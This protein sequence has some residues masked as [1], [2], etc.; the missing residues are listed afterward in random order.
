MAKIAGFFN[1]SNNV[2]FAIVAIAAV[3]PLWVSEFPPLVDLPQHA[4]QV[5]ALHEL[6]SGN[7]FYSHDL[8]IN[9]FTPY[10]FG[11]LLL[12]L[13]SMV[14]PLMVATK[15]L[16]SLAVIALPVVSGLLLRAMGGDERLKWLAIPAGYSFALYWGFFVYLVAVPVGLTLAYLTV[17]YEQS[18]T[19]KRSIGIAALAIALF[20][21]HAMALGFGALIS[22]TY[23]LAKNFRNPLRLIRLSLP[24]A[25]P[26]PI[27]A[28]WMTHLIDTDA[29]VRDAPYKPGTLYEK[30]VV[31]FTQFSGLDGA[32]FGTTFALF[33]LAGL[34]PVLGGYRISSKP[35]RWLP[36]LVG[37]LVYLAF[38]SNA[39]NT[40]YLFHRLAVFLVPLWLIMWDP[41]QRFRPVVFFAFL[42]MIGVWLT[43]N[44]NRF[45]EFSRESATFSKVL[46]Q[47]EPGK[48]MAGLMV[49]NGSPGFAYPVY[50]HFASWYQAEY[51]GIADRS[52]ATAHPSLVRYRDVRARR[53]AKRISWQP[54]AFRWDRDG[55][56]SYDYFIVCAP[57]DY[58]AD[59]FKDHLN[60]VEL[61]AQELPWW[62][63]RKRT[64]NPVATTP[65]AAAHLQPTGRQD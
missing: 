62:L 40:A 1:P 4:A 33:A 23:L 61:V 46:R 53:V 18:P 26:L 60:S 31:L 11:Y 39:Q 50:L 57:A 20:F 45:I 36:M 65:A 2:L 51:R 49:C 15:L 16:V 13:A 29:A 6:L 47:A 24:Y 54:L 35:E 5:A 34:L 30:L 12:Y 55:G 59:I 52:F 42:G 7:S 41:P 56:P 28:I 43:V 17:A 27:L 8:T 44:G 25:A 58:S 63:Y 19:I 9:W 38:P 3:V 22:L 21:C 14:L 10:L 64:E 48:R 32:A 37:L